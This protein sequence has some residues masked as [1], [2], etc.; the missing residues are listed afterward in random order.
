MQSIPLL[1]VSLIGLT[2]FSPVVAED[3]KLETRESLETAVPEAIRLLKQ[4]NYE[5]FVKTFLPPA[6]LDEVAERTSL[7]EF[8]KTFGEQ[9]SMRLLLVLKEIKDA[10]PELDDTATTASFALKTKIRGRKSITF[11]KIEKYWYIKN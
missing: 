10:K 8:A 4:R 7:E 6:L 5:T 1:L 3:V 11:V 2:L 9:K